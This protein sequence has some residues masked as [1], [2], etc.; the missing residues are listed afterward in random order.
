MIISHFRRLLNPIQVY[1]VIDSPPEKV[2]TWLKTTKLEC[3]YVLVAGGDGTV[4]GVLNGIHNLQ[5]KV[6]KIQ[7]FIE[8]LFFL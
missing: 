8:Y 4:G 5:L 1:D 3:I 2:L 7:F 6:L